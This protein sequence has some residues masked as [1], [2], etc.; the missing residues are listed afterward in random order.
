MNRK[1]AATA[2]IALTI[3]GLAACSRQA[4][5]TGDFV[6]KVE[7]GGRQSG[8]AVT[9]T[10]LVIEGGR[11]LIRLERRS[12]FEAKLLGADVTAEG[13]TTYLLEPAT[14]RVL[15]HTGS[16][17]SQTQEVSWSVE[18]R[19][20]RAHG[21]STLKQDEMVLDLPPDAMVENDLFY[22]H[23]VA[24]FA[25]TGLAEKTYSVLDVIDF[26]IRDTRYE[27]HAEEPFELDGYWYDVIVVDRSVPATGTLVRMWIDTATAM[28]VKVLEQDGNV[29]TLAD[30]SVTGRVER[31]ELDKYILDKVDVAIADVPGI[32]SMKVRATIRP[33]GMKPTPESL[34]VPGQKFTGTVTD[35]LVEGVFEIE[36]ARYDGTGAPSFPPEAAAY[37][38]LDEFLDADGIFETDDAVLAAEAQAITAG[39]ADAW[40]AATRLAAWVADEIGYAIPGGGTARNTYD[41]RAGECGAHSIL[42][43]TFCRAVG[44][45]ARMVWG[46]M[47]TPNQGGSFGQHGWTEIHMGPAGWIPVDATAGETDFVDSG[48]IRVAHYGSVVSRLNA[49]EFEI[50]DYRVAGGSAEA[51]AAA[52]E[53]FAAYLGEYGQSE[54]DQNVVVKVM[55]GS[56]VVD[57]EGRALLALDEPDEQGRRVCLVAKHLYVEFGS[58]GDDAVTS[59]ELHETYTLPRG[60]APD[61]IDERVPADLAAYLGPYRMAALNADFEVR[62][63]RGGLALKH[64][65]V[66]RGFRLTETGDGAWE[67]ENG[68]YVVA[69]VTGQDGRVAAM[70][71]DATTEFKR[72]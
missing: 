55:D 39:A 36:H 41:M 48:H 17:S 29:I 10:S 14:K 49:R 33:I 20:G 52:A 13:L 37:A 30:P 12:R 19:D 24:D 32:T 54:S 71:L 7:T 42:L 27:K 56:L 34:N 11:E 59:V 38:G 64:P 1:F 58:V 28:V 22:D 66:D 18:I 5:E 61:A 45:P 3:G 21:A 72:R 67:T 6:Y 60:N 9:D 44:I 4:D 23:L 70:A 26:E 46:C 50:L 68:S 31:V 63:E 25:G 51:T 69:F 15:A 43:A 40:E 8:Y 2:I 47:Y 62:W 65:R 16:S 57:L 53:R 35:N